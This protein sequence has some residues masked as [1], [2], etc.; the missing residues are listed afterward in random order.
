M[1]VITSQQERQNDEI[2]LSWLQVLAYADPSNIYSR[3]MMG[4]IDFDLGNYEAS[5]AQMAQVLA[6]TSSAD[7][8]SSAYTYMALS[9]AGRGDYIDE[10]LLLL[11]AVILDPSYWNNT[12]REELSGLR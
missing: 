8:R 2:A 6:R 10:R 1:R 5:A 7:I 4:R 12:A 11:Q 9:D 3:Y